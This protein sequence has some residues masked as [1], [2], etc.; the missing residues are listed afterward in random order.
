ME[1]VTKLAEEL[2]KKI[3]AIEKSANDKTEI[4]ALKSEL[5]NVASKE[6]V[7]KLSADLDALSIQ[8]KQKEEPIVELGAT[9]KEVKEQIEKA[10]EAAK[11]RNGQGVKLD[12]TIKAVA[13]VLTT[14]VTAAA[15][16]NVVAMTESLG[17]V[18]PLV[19]NRI[20]FEDIL[21]PVPTTLDT[22][23]W[24]DEV[25]KEGDAA[26]TAEGATKGQSDI[27]YVERTLN[28]QNV[29][30]FI[31]VST[32]MLSQPNYIVSAIQNRL[33]SRL[34][35][36]KQSQLVDGDGTAP[37]ISGLNVLAT[38]FAVG[39]YA[40]TVEDAN[41]FDLI[42]VIV[43]Q[44][45]TSGEDFIPNYAVVSHGTLAKMDL[46]KGL[47]GHYV[48]PPFISSDRTT[49]SGVK[50]IGSNEYTDDEMLVGD[51]TKA[52]YAYKDEIRV[53]AG[54]DGNDFTK[55]LVTI[56]AEQ[57]IGL[58]VSENEKSAFRFVSDIDAAVADLLK[59]EA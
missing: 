9:I 49:I 10:N 24:I 12:F 45:S 40:D 33:L 37:N 21:N 18:K 29:T 54:L 15:G 47:D 30:H 19:Q 1:D 44:I 2:N 14:N 8:L 57:P 7:A 50:V 22:I 26:M 38:D 48:L 52:N 27:S 39:A 13:P 6:D 16:G 55:N 56:L 51:F 43:A 42:R 32:K 17:I 36:K 53:S 28:L 35:L 59:P 46:E 20:F 4:N 58:F 25:V 11:N 41:I 31:K 3:E 5:A 23:T 34:R